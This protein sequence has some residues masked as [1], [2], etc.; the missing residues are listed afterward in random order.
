MIFRQIAVGPMANLVYLLGCPQTRSAVLVDCGFDAARIAA[1]IASEKLLLTHILLTHVHYDHAGAAE[2]LAGLTGARIMMHPA[3]R[4]KQ[5]TP[6][7]RGM[8]IVPKE[9]DDLLP[10]M[11][12]DVGSL[13]IEV[14]AAPGHQQDHLLFLSDP[15][16]LTGDT[17]FVGGAGR[18]DFP[19]SDP[20][21]LRAT[22]RQIV[23]MP[24]HLIICPGHD[25]GEKPIQTLGEAK[26]ANPFLQ[27]LI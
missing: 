27:G 10:G 13:K 9:T 26:K 20:D 16:L 11:I 25:Y 17:L 7:R 5:N 23:A 24:D 22:L 3:S 19:D 18:T 4:A 1:V 21:A 12:L 2:E 8:W 15:Y 6:A 14:I